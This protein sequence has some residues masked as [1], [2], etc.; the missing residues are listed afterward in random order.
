MD[1]LCWQINYFKEAFNRNW[2]DFKIEW[3]YFC[4]GLQHSLQ[5]I[6]GWLSFNKFAVAWTATEDGLDSWIIIVPEI[7][8]EMNYLFDLAI[9]INNFGSFDV[10]LWMIF[11]D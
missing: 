9:I 7:V 5:D 2:D 8:I 4:M 1:L 6:I 10:R 11:E 3:N